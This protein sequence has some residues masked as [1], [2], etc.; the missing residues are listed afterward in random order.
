[1]S[2]F[3]AEIHVVKMRT[4]LKICHKDYNLDAYHFS[5][6]HISGPK[7]LFQFHLKKIF[8]FITTVIRFG[9]NIL[10]RNLTKNMFTLFVDPNTNK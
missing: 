6:L 8:V 3:R 1:M 2:L 10:V 9:A 7:K 5:V 4:A